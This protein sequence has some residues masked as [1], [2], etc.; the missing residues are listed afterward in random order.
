MAV[1]H[2]RKAA[3]QLDELQHPVH[4][5]IEVGPQQLLANV[6]RAAALDAHNAHV[7]TQWL[8]GLAVIGRKRFVAQQASEQINLGHTRLP[9]QRPRQL[10]DIFY[11]SA[12]IGIAPH[13]Q[14]LAAHQAVNAEQL[15]VNAVLCHEANPQSSQQV[16]TAHSLVSC[17][18]PLDH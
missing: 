6:T 15:N 1:H 12:G 11:L 4:E 13:L 17:H 9:A 14:I 3:L 8:D 18:S 5:L 2:V 10:D 7:F 16:V